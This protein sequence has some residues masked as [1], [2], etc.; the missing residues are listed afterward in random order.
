MCHLHAHPAGFILDRKRGLFH[1]YLVPFSQ[2]DPSSF[3]AQNLSNKAAE[4]AATWHPIY[5]FWA[6]EKGLT[7][8]PARWR[9]TCPGTETNKSCFVFGPSWRLQFASC[10]SIAPWICDCM[11][12]QSLLFDSGSPRHHR[13]G[14]DPERN[15]QTW[16]RDPVMNQGRLCLADCVALM[17][18]CERSTWS[19][20]TCDGRHLRPPPYVAQKL[21]PLLY[22]ASKVHFPVNPSLSNLPIW[23][24]KITWPCF[25]LFAPYFGLLLWAIAGDYINHPEQI[26]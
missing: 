3:S 25:S 6:A 12:V 14:S 19:L 8:R 20:W 18:D 4:I 22:P 13:P 1:F 11:S 16:G 2:Q 9:G 23:R 7:P 15:K 5:V 17:D 10:H 24:T 21:S 26:F